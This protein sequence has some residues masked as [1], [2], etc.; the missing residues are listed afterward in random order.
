MIQNLAN[1]KRTHRRTRLFV[2]FVLIAGAIVLITVGVPRIFGG[3]S[4]WIAQF[5]LRGGARAVEVTSGAEYVVQSKRSVFA[6]N[7]RLRAENNALLLELKDR[8]ILYTENLQLKELFHRTFDR[9]LILAAVLSKPNR[10]AYDT[11][12]VDAGADDGVGV[13]SS[14]F[15]NGTIL[16]GTVR[17]VYKDTS[18]VVLF[19]SPGEVTGGLVGDTGMHAEITGRGGGAF[20]VIVPRDLIFSPGMPVVSPTV[21]S[22]VIAEIDQ[23][24][25]DPRDPFQKVIGRSPVN[26]HNLKWVEIAL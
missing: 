5:A 24:V 7:E 4:H 10:S 18:L 9:S 6:E 2:I 25:S 20:E 23:I 13:G 19:S 21:F 15:A 3:T 11:L 22:S 14:V 1:R 26:M 8:D 16:L 12:I 17:E